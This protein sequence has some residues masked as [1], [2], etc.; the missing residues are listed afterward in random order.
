MF[1]RVFHNL[2]DYLSVSNILIYPSKL[3]L[4]LIMLFLLDS[5]RPEGLNSE[6]T[7]SVSLTSLVLQPLQPKIYC[8]LFRSCC[9]LT[10]TCH[11]NIVL[12][13]ESIMLEKYLLP[14][15][16][17]FSFKNKGEIFSI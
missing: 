7:P 9:A 2:K 13:S 6:A 3:S 14:H 17:P 16:F 11:E 12:V 5:W 15:T 1:T 8:L 10:P 4:K